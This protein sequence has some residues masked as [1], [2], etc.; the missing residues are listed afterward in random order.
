MRGR[1]LSCVAVLC[2]AA[3]RC[4]FFRTYSST[5]YHA[6][7]CGV[8]V[9]ARVLVFL[10]ASSDCFLSVLMLFSSKLHPYCLSERRIANKHNAQHRAIS[11]AQAALGIIKSP[12]APNHGPLLFAPF[13]VLAVFLHE[14]SGRCQLPA[15]RSPCARIPGTWYGPLQFE[16]SGSVLCNSS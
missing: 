9:F 16:K 4:A 8:S 5:R 15:E 14:R 12:V 6:K 3:L 13:T 10:L 2:R 1:A 7:W 11:S